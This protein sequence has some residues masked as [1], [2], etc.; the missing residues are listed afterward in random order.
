MCKKQYIIQFACC[1]LSTCHS[2]SRHLLRKIGIRGEMRAGNNAWRVPH[3][4][5]GG[6]TISVSINLPAGTQRWLARAPAVLNVVLVILIGLAAA[7]LFW[8]LWPASETALAI[9][10]QASTTA[11]GTRHADADY[12][13]AAITGAN[14]FGKAKPDTA[15]LAPKQMIEAPET[16][17]SLTLTGIVSNRAGG[18]SRALIKNNKDEQ[19]SYAVGDNIISGVVLHDIYV[20]KV[21]LERNGRY[22]TLTLE[23]VKKAQHMKRGVQQVA[24]SDDSGSPSLHAAA[25]QADAVP[26]DS[27]NPPR[28]L[29]TIRD[30][31]LANP[32]RAER[33]IRLQPARANGDLIG[34][35]IYPGSDRGL[36]EQTGLQS[37]AIVTAINGQPLNNSAKALQLLSQIAHAPSVTLTVEYNGQ[38]RTVTMRFE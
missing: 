36:F 25:G 4:D 3:A 17:L 11:S 23:S 18:R 7:R 26:A 1:L 37:G 13:M 24:A 16:H 2:R 33:Y 12:S 35:S 29:S 8:Q 38:P 21:I 14:L 31:I 22:E 34:Y 28:Q 30:K 5:K 9:G 27:D 20:N 32:A 10:A 15:A 19:N 6:Y